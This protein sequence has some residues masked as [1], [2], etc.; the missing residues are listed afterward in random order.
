MTLSSGSGPTARAAAQ[1]GEVAPK[2][3]KVIRLKTA[4][5]VKVDLPEFGLLN[6]II[7]DEGKGDL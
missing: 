5:G 4:V 2:A 3:N 7:L 6:F 1:A